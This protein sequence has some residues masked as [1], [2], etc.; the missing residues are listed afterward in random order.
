MLLIPILIV[1]AQMA[2]ERA[3]C[4]LNLMLMMAPMATLL[5]NWTEDRR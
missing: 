2:V 4:V 3:C 5:A 1:S